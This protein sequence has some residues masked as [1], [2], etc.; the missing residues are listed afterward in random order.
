MRSGAC[1][2]WAI[3]WSKIAHQES[4][5][6]IVH[7]LGNSVNRPPSEVPAHALQ[8]VPPLTSSSVFSPLAAYLR[9]GELRKGKPVARWGAKLRASWRRHQGYRKEAPSHGSYPPSGGKTGELRYE[10]ESA[11]RCL[12][13][14]TSELPHEQLQA[15]V[16]LARNRKNGPRGPSCCKWC[17]V[18][19]HFGPFASVH[20]GPF[21]P[22]SYQRTSVTA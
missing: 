9:T 4:E 5:L 22:S 6:R 1:R 19:A 17:T 12:Y 3:Y 15:K 20:F 14:P 2:K 8:A 13:S 7:L 16:R 11:P 18:A 10:D 21:S